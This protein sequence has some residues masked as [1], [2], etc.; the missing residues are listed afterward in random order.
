MEGERKEGEEREQQNFD[1][2]IA[3]E[4]RR[5]ERGRRSMTFVRHKDFGEERKKE[6]RCRKYSGEEGILH[7]TRRRHH[8]QVNDRWSFLRASVCH[9]RTN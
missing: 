1:M 3:K 6:E 2:F 8:S 4:E 7:R 9:G 5:R